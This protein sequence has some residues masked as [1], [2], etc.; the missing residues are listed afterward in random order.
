MAWCQL[1]KS[2]VRNVHNEKFQI[3]LQG[4]LF[5][6]LCGSTLMISPWF[7]DQMTISSN[8]PATTEKEDQRDSI[9][10]LALLKKQTVSSDEFT[11]IFNVKNLKTP[12][13][14]FIRNLGQIPDDTIQYYCSVNGLFA[15]FSH[16]KII[17]IDTE[18]DE[19]ESVSFSISFLGSHEISPKGIS[20]KNQNINFLLRDSQ[21]TRFPNSDEIWYYDLYPGIDLR[22]YISRFGLKY[23]FII[24]SRADP[25]QITMKISQSMTLSVGKYAISFQSITHPEKVRFQDTSLNVFQ[26]DGTEIAAHFI[27]KDANQQS[28]GFQVAPFDHT[29]A[30]IIDP[31]I[32]NAPSDFPYE[33]G[34]TANTLSWTAIED[35]NSSA[36]YTIYRNNTVVVSSGWITNTPVTLNVDGLAVGFYNYTIIFSDAGSNS[37]TNQTWVTVVDTTAPVVSGVSDFS[38]ELGSTGHTLNWTATDRT[39]RIYA[40]YRNGMVI[41]SSKWINGTPVTINIDGL[42]VG[43]YNYTII[44]RDSSGNNATDQVWVN[45]QDLIAPTIALGSQ[46]PINGSIQHSGTPI[47][48]I[49]KDTN[50]DTI[51]FHWDGD[52]N[53]SLNAPYLTTLP[54]G[55]DQHI[56]HIYTNDTAGNWAYQRFIFTT[57]DNPPVIESSVDVQYEVGATGNK[58]SWTAF[59]AHPNS[60]VIHI[61]GTLVENGSWISLI[62]IFYNIDDLA[63]GTYNF[64]ITVVDETGFVTSDTTWVSVTRPPQIPLSPWRDLFLLLVGGILSLA[65]VVMARSPVQQLR[66]GLATGWIKKE[67]IPQQEPEGLLPSKPISYRFNRGLTAGWIKNE[68]IEKI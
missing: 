57:D 27:P 52:N 4:G 10:V 61:N 39:P 47:E 14:R 5:V 65:I 48:I 25:E 26:E 9:D 24:H 33:L 54:V 40:I 19:K 42:T 41:A 37:A 63:V 66:R 64:T 59:D 2:I 18:Q 17:F 16:S 34:D 49:V 31:L 38:Y 36:D 32:T 12:N 1:L 3:I 13:Y 21:F 55:D 44:F 35:L 43:L 8:S 30:L 53:Q 60:Y 29:Q 58:I 62:P 51:Q 23:D 67:N 50:L 7:W 46:S 22:Y 20:R 28:Y 15:G 6:I 45:V 56:L 11:E 68:K